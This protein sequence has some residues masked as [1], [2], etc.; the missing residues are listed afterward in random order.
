V[1]P[2]RAVTYPF[3]QQAFVV[4]DLDRS[5]EEW[6]RLFGAGPFAIRPHHRANILETFAAWRQA[7]ASRR[8][9]DPAVLPVDGPASSNIA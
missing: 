1:E 2:G 8:R 9:S 4:T 7:H 5:V 6:S 3:F